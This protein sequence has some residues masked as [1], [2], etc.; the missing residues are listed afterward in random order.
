[1]TISY[2]RQELRRL[3][4]L[5][6]RHLQDYADDYT[7]N[8]RVGK[9]ISAHQLPEVGWDS[10]LQFSLEVTMRGRECHSPA[11]TTTRPIKVPG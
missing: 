6:I 11:G 9:I 2:E 1:M 10:T 8:C 7:V 3:A 4:L 5:P